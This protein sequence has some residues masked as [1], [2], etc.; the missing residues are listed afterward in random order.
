M[1]AV[2]ALVGAATGRPPNAGQ[3]RQQEIPAPGSPHPCA[4]VAVALDEFGGVGA[5][6]RFALQAG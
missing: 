4:V 3:P 5:L 2:G 1:G 6:L